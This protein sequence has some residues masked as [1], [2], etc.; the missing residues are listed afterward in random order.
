VAPDRLPQFQIELSDAD[1]TLSM[2]AVEED[3]AIE[4][5]ADDIVEV[6]QVRST[7]L[8]QVLAPPKRSAI[9][10]APVTFET[11]TTTAWPPPVKAWHA[12]ACAAALIVG[13]IGALGG[14]IRVGAGL[15]RSAHASPAPSRESAP[16]EAHELVPVREEATLAPVVAPVAFVA[17]RAHAA[18]RTGVIRVGPSVRGML[19]DG[20]PTR[21]TGGAVVV[22]CG[23]HRTKT[24]IAPSRSVDVPCG[25]SAW[26]F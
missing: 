1:A 21:V 24:G 2:P 8:P 12:A 19:V 9:S 5:V 18:S 10:I 22:S 26:V 3:G 25:G 7:E 15:V 13:S 16:S 14:G 6:V 20:A 4:L 17:H 11:E 23:P